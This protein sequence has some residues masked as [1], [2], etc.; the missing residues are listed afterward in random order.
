MSMLCDPLPA[1]YPWSVPTLHGT[2][3]ALVFIC[4]DRLGHY[5]SVT[6]VSVTDF[7]G[8]EV[9]GAAWRGYPSTTSP[10]NPGVDIW[11]VDDVPEEE[12]EK[13]SSDDDTDGFD[14]DED[15]DGLITWTEVEQPTDDFDENDFDDD[16]DDDF[17]VDMEN[18][19]FEDRDGDLEIEDG[20]QDSV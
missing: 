3:P 6:D 4:P 2:S 17:E 13:T 19:E 18:E 8:I 15:E 11:A 9:P 1:L 12:G 5:V 14:R 20:E 16:F 7:S 10:V